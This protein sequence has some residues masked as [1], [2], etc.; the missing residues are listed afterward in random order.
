MNTFRV[1]VKTSF[2]HNIYYNEL[3]KFN[4]TTTRKLSNFGPINVMQTYH[5]SLHTS[6][7]MYI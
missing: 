4:T 2:D 6:K 7:H 5:Q 3:H 1:S